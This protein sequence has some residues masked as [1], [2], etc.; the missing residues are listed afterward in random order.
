[1][2]LLLC[3]LYLNLGIF[4]AGYCSFFTSA[5]YPALFEL[6]FKMF[7]TFSKG[8]SILYFLKKIFFNLVNML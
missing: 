8:K 6:F 5:Q 7:I 4:N 1:M 2:N 3:L